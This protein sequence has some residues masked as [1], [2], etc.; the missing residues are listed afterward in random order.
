MS[1]RECIR[2]FFINDFWKLQDIPQIQYFKKPKIDE[3]SIG[4]PTGKFTY[5]NYTDKYFSV[6]SEKNYQ[7]S[8]LDESLIS[9]YYKF[10]ET[11]EIE[12]YN[13]SFV[14]SIDI[15]IIENDY[16]SEEVFDSNMMDYLRIDYDKQGYKEVV[17][18]LQHLHI[19]LTCHGKK[20]EDNRNELRIPVV[21]K[22]YPWDFI[23]LI[24]KYIYNID[25]EYD[26]IFNSF[27]SDRGG[28]IN[29]E[30]QIFYIRFD[31]SNKKI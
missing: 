16:R 6:I 23:Y 12:K 2:N 19:G 28:L 22:I 24:A 7:I 10:Y 3:S 5:F 17:H 13:L 25:D 18:E 27:N 8:F 30:K 29:I 14:P 21:D 20:K 15:E 26:K 1:D 31:S 9:M 11:G 4:V